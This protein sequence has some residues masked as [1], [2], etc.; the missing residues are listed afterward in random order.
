VFYYF[1]LNNLCKTYE[2]TKTKYRKVVA[3]YPI[4]DSAVSSFFSSNIKHILKVCP[5]KW[6]YASSMKDE[7][8]FTKAAISAEKSN[9]SY[10]K[11]FKFAETHNL[12]ALKNKIQ[13][14]RIYSNILVDFSGVQN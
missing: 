4:Q 3:V 11:L 6:C 1:L 8:L 2:T 5:V 12:K 13:K 7:E 14:N 9:V 10:S